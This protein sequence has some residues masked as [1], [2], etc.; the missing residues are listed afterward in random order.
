MFLYFTGYQLT[1]LF[2]SSVTRNEVTVL[3]VVSMKQESR[4]GE[5][6]REKERDQSTSI[7]NMKHTKSYIFV[8]VRGFLR[9]SVVSLTKDVVE[10]RSKILFRVDPN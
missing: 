6:E 10:Y 5:R 9:H 7:R 3:I 2:K 1:S 8:N 4:K